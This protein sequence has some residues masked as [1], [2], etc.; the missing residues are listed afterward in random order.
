MSFAH[1]A[2]LAETARINKTPKDYQVGVRIHTLDEAVAE[3]KRVTDAASQPHQCATCGAM[4][5][6]FEP[7]ERDDG[8]FTTMQAKAIG[9]AL[10]DEVRLHGQPITATVENHRAAGLR[11]VP[12]QIEAGA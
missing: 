8:R 9:R 6:G 7:K 2:M 3:F 11:E 5:G 1:L 10:D 12:T 4:A